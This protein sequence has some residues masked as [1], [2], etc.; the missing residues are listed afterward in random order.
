MH[1]R[2]LARNSPEREEQY[3]LKTMEKRSMDGR[4]FFA[5]QARNFWLV[6]LYLTSWVGLPP[7]GRG[8]HLP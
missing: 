6:F 3:E 8:M 5:A 2:E 1:V 4:G 7:T